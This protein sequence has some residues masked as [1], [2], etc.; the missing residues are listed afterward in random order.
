MTAPMTPKLDEARLRGLAEAATQG[1]WKACGTIYEYMNCEIRSGRKGEGQAIAQVW[2]GPNAFRDGQ[3][4]A[5][6]SPA[7]ILALLDALSAERER[8]DRAVRACEIIMCRSPFSDA[9]TEITDYEK[10]HDDCG[11]WAFGI[12]ASGLATQKAEGAET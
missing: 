9:A 1:E 11:A 10:G 4:I 8:G 5:A 7:T 12:A 2:D 3:H 6:C